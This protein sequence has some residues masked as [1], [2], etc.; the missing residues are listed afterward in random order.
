MGRASETQSTSTAAATLLQLHNDT[1]S[2]T[3]FDSREPFT[4]ENTR[5]DPGRTCDTGE[6]R[7]TYTKAWENGPYASRNTA[8]FPDGMN[9]YSQINMQNTIVGLTNAIGNLQQEQIN[10]H[11]RQDNITGTLGQVLSVLQVLRDGTGS[12][13]SISYHNMVQNTGFPQSA[14]NNS[15]SMF[16]ESMGDKHFTNQNCGQAAELQTDPTQNVRSADRHYGYRNYRSEDRHSRDDNISSVDRHYGYRNY[17]SEDRHSRDDNI[18]SVDRHY[19]YR[20]YRMEDRHSGSRSESSIDRHHG[21][22]HGTAAPVTSQSDRFTPYNE[23][24]LTPTEENTESRYGPVTEDTGNAVNLANRSQRYNG[25]RD[26]EGRP[27][28]TFS[29]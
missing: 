24:E 5:S 18:S 17:R 4:D 29:D 2:D 8:H 10:M 22:N 14:V 27:S 21:S 6:G 3:H 15:A 1:F 23:I 19:G 7:P 20:N 26:D 28:V 16:S 12:A 25:Q 9:M 13:P 11:T